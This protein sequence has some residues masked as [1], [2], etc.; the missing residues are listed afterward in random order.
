[1]DNMIGLLLYVAALLQL[2]AA[3]N[4]TVDLGYARYRGKEIG[5]GVSR[6]AGMR[7]ARSVSRVDGLRFTAP[8][9]PLEE[10]N[11]VTTDASKVSIHQ[12]PFELKLL[13]VIV[14]TSLHRH[15][16]RPHS[17]IRQQ[18]VGRLSLCQCICSFEGHEHQQA[19]SLCF[20][21]R[22]WIQHERQ[23]KL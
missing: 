8:Q 19:P 2:A 1:L 3:V 7:Y 5:N 14:R 21:S 13:T 16:K 9:E 4:V 18:M 11:K 22:R 12:R 20:H 15:P 23:R 10:P 17:R 6:W